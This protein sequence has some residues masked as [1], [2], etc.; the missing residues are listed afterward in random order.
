[1]QF[2]L[3]PD[4]TRM[5]VGGEMTNEVLVL[6]ATQEMD[7][8]VIATL[9]VPAGPWHP[10]FSPDG[11]RVYLPNI[12]ANTI[13]EIDTSD[14]SIVREIKDARFAAPHG[15]AMSPDG[16][17]LYVG[18]RNEKPAADGGEPG[19]GFVAVIDTASGRVVK[20]IEVGRY[21]A[22]MGAASGG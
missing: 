9:D 22:G 4:G 12:R 5:V 17:K 14:W 10:A 1:V 11:T 6:D 13:S 15:I 2:G 8:P 20:F 7:P 19:N 18:N 16:R 21:A 3:S